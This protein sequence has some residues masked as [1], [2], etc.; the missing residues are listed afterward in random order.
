MIKYS[1]EKHATC[2]TSYV[3]MAHIQSGTLYILYGIGAAPQ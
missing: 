2:S 3:G 1:I